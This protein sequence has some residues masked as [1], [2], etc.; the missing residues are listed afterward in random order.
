M[1]ITGVTGRGVL[2]NMGIPVSAMAIVKIALR[3][4]AIVTVVGITVMGIN[5][6]ASVAVMA[7]HR[8]GHTEIKEEERKYAI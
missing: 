1:M 6:A 2:A 5:A 7:A 8:A 3:T 4:T